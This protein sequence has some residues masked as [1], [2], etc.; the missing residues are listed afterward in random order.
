M[1]SCSVRPR[2]EGFAL[3]AVL[4]VTAVVTLIFIVALT[5]LDSLNREASNARARVDFTARAM[6][7]EARVVYLA[8]TEPIGPQAILVGAALPMDDLTPLPPAAEMAG[9]VVWIDGRPHRDEALA[10]RITLQDAAGQLNLANLSPQAFRR[11]AEELGVGEDEADRL[12]AALEDYVDSDGERRLNGAEARDYGAASPPSQAPLRAPDELLSVLG[13]RERIRASVWRTLRDELTY[14]SL[15]TQLNVNT[16][17]AALLRIGFGL[18]PAEAAAVM[19]ARQASPFQSAPEFVAASGAR[20]PILGEESVTSPSPIF[21]I[22]VADD[23]SDSV[24]RSR[25]TLTPSND[26]R[27]FWIDRREFSREDRPLERAENVA[28]FP[29]AAR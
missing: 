22:R 20:E 13:A 23:G 17:N 25:L 14:D 4:T 3:P 26:F 8:S 28:E 19:E 24:Y 6:S 1:I 29:F 15:R 27:P 21:S 18:T 5:A 9:S 7:A 16:A 12:R 2:R 10:V 11:L